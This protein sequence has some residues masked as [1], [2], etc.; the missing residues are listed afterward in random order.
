VEF[1]GGNNPATG[2]WQR[3]FGHGLKIEFMR[4][5]LIFMKL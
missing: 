1:E 3:S 5:S 2:H 4:I